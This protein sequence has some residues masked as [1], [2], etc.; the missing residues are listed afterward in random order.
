MQL[1]SSSASTGPSNCIPTQIFISVFLG[2][3]GHS[4][5]VSV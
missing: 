3:E 1:N 4:R 2:M 5:P